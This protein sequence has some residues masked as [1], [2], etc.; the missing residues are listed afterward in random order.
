MYAFKKAI[1]WFKAGKQKGLKKKS[2]LFAL[3]FN[4]FLFYLRQVS[5]PF[6]Y[7]VIYSDCE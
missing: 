2:A 1:H 7:P 6:F 4:T 5:C 3:L